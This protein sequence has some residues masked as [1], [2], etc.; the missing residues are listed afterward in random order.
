M[1][2]WAIGNRRPQNAKELFNLR[3]SSLRNAIERIF[4]VVKKRFPLLVT[5]RSFE[6]SFHCDI[7]MCSL[8]LHNFIRLNQLNEDYFYDDDV[9]VVQEVNDNAEEEVVG[10]ANY[11]YQWR[12]GIANAMWDD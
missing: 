12:N 6:F 8:M 10:N 11:L 5:M 3:H 9:D 4:G 7:V 1:K 2:E